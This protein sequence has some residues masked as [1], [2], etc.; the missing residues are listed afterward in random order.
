[1]LGIKGD[2]IVELFNNFLSLFQIK[3][4]ARYDV[5]GE[6][7]PYITLT[8]L[9]VVDKCRPVRSSYILVSCLLGGILPAR[10]PSYQDT[11]SVT[12]IVGIT[13]FIFFST[14]TV[15]HSIVCQLLGLFIPVDR[16]T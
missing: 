7:C 2:E 10:R 16:I 4:K 5:P 11:N 6:S 15:K 9:P 1:M 14:V 8:L 12:I 13:G 3:Q